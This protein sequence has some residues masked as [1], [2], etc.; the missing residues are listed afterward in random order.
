MRSVLR[1]GRGQ[2]MYSRN[3]VYNSAKLRVKAFTRSRFRSLAVLRRT[4]FDSTLFQQ[5]VELLKVAR[6]VVALTGAGISTPSGIPDFRSPETGLWS[7]SDPLEI[8]S[9]WGFRDK[10][11]RFYDWFRSLTRDIVSARPNS[12]H[13]ALVELEKLGK[14]FC[15]ITQNIDQLHQRAGSNNVLELH[16]HLRTLTCLRCRFHDAA[17]TYLHLFVNTGALPL[18]PNCGS[19]LK[20]DVVLFGEP[21]PESILLAAQEETLRCDLMLVVGSSLEVMP[22]ADLPPLAVRRGARLIIVNLGATPYD[23]LADVVLNGDVAAVLPALV[24]QVAAG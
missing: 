3:L 11:Q 10:P 16:G 22:A 4:R 8:A 13:Q 1:Q 24:K 12:A 23:H 17:E 7:Q 18:C 2:A 15:L 5:A 14:V 21:L 6:R 9:I 20:P 19:I